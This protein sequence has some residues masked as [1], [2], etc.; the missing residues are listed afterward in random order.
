MLDKLPWDHVNIKFGR[1]Y[2]EK[3]QTRSTLQ[4]TEMAAAI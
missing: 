1:T 2:L 3:E 4:L